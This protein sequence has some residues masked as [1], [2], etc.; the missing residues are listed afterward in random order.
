VAA[1][2]VRVLVV[3]VAN[4]AIY[5][6]VMPGPFGIGMDFVPLDLTDLKGVRLSDGTY[7]VVVITPDGTRAFGKLVILK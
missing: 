1:A 4:R 3:T 6:K 7:Y 2:Q 5:D